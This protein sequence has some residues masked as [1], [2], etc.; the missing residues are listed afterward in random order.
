[1]THIHASN[2]I[3]LS[4]SDANNQNQQVITQQELEKFIIEMI[5]ALFETIQKSTNYNAMEQQLQANSGIAATQASIHANELV[6]QKV[7][8]YLHKL[9]E[10]HHRS[11]WQKIGD[12]FNSTFGKVLLGAISVA[13]I[14]VSLG[15]AAP[16][17]LAADAAIAGSAA[18]TGIAVT[19]SA[20]SVA[21]L[22]AAQVTGGLDY[23]FK[24]INS[25]LEKLG[26]K[27]GL[28]GKALDI[29]KAL[30]DAAIVVA[31]TLIVPSATASSPTTAAAGVE[32]VGLVEKAA[33]ETEVA[34]ASADAVEDGS[35]V[36]T[37]AETRAQNFN[38]KNSRIVQLNSFAILASSSGLTEQMAVVGYEMKGDS[39]KE[40]KEKAKEVAL[41]MNLAL[42]F[43][44]IVGTGALSTEAISGNTALDGLSVSKVYG[45]VNLG[46]NDLIT[47]LMGVQF[48]VSAL[49]VGNDVLKG[50]QLEALGNVYNALA[51]AEGVADHLAV[52]AKISNK[53]SE[54]L[55]EQ[56]N[57]TQ[58]Q[59]RPIYEMLPTLSSYLFAESQM[60]QKA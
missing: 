13:V 53:T 57:E 10:S 54:K 31:A 21:A 1:M 12:F 9:D 41:F 49:N 2:G 33:T 45:N 52:A 27:L 18:T 17:A 16:A 29:F 8:E 32:D 14:M 38:V 4:T 39:A 28:H 30:C 22:T 34:V 20:V 24:G 19:T 26:E 59:L 47:F 6:Q 51:K 55:S 48:T 43:L 15:T 42:S 60:M 5:M 44:A 7:K 40:S 58:A 56:L 23:A 46:L 3:D 36:S 25:G 37:S 35:Q 11:W 50:N